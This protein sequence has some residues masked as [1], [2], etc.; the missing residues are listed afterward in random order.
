MQTPCPTRFG[1]KV[2]KT[3][4]S[5]RDYEILDHIKRYR[6]TTRDVL[7]KLFFADSDIS[8]VSKVTSRLLQMDVL[9][10]YAL[11]A[12]RVYFGLGEI[13]AK[14][15]GLSASKASAHGPQALIDNY[16]VLQFCCNGA[17]PR[18]R[19]LVSELKQYIGDIRGKK[20][21]PG[22]FYIDY[23]GGQSRLA[24]MR[25]DHGSSPAHLIRRSREYLER[26]V[27]NPGIASLIRQK[28]LMLTIL[29]A[30]DDKKTQI[31]DCISRQEWKVF[32]RVEVVKGLRPLLAAS[33]QK[34]Q[35][36]G[37]EF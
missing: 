26:V 19:L 12:D 9:Q 34:S 17:V 29:T 35:L 36:P 28:S 37:A 16:A 5:D 14:L 31:E 13:A 1:E 24:A 15:H 10:K 6:M 2:S 25:V 22:M 30:F 27:A 4:L 20:L 33:A 8:A 23:Q 21:R 3:R 7:Q 32:F 11:D 18:E